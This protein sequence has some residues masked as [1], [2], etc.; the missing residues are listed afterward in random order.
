MLLFT[1]TRDRQTGM[2]CFRIPLENGR[3]KIFFE[4]KEKCL[5]Y[6]FQRFADADLEWAMKLSS[7]L[8]KYDPRDD[9]IITQKR[10][11]DFFEKFI[12]ENKDE[13]CKNSD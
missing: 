11:M 1:I 4:S 8:I 3:K 6:V 10:L 5:L 9:L 2:F 13:I 12:A 7:A